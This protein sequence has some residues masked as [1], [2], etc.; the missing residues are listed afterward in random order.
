MPIISKPKIFH[1]LK[2]DYLHIFQLPLK[3]SCIHLFVLSRDECI[4]INTYFLLNTIKWEAKQFKVYF[5]LNVFTRCETPIMS[6]LLCE[7]NSPICPINV[8]KQ[9]FLYSYLP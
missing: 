8:S 3:V 7:L 4:E 6:K 2:C 1:I 9:R 5:N